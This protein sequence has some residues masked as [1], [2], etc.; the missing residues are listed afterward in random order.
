MDKVDLVYNEH[1]MTELPISVR[2]SAEA[3][4]RLDRIAAALS[5]RAAGAPMNRSS[6]VRVAVGRGIDALEA[7]LGLSKRPKPKRS[8]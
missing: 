3:V 4:E 7:E 1:E 2:L 5:D 8:K 6:V